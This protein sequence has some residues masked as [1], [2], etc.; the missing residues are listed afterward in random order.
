MALSKL[1]PD[2]ERVEEIAQRIKEII[3]TT[4]LRDPKL[5][6]AEAAEFR[7]LRTEIENM[8]MHVGHETRLNLNDLSTPKLEADITIWIPKNTT[9]Q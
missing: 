9:I 6:D 3:E 4:W 7:A 5:N 2:E 8:G 1:E